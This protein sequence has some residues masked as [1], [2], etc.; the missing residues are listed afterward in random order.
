MNIARSNGHAEIIRMEADADAAA[1]KYTDSENFPGV[2]RA[3]R[4]RTRRP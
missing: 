3:A 2:C 4:V 1:A